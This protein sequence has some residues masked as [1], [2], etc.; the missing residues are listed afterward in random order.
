[1][2]GT[3]LLL[4]LLA[5]LVG[6]L[7]PFQAAANATLSRSLES[8]GYAALTLFAVALFST[9][10]LLALFRVPPPT[11][12][13]FSEAP[14]YGFL[15]GLVVATYV[16]SITF[17]VPR[18]GVA[19]AIF[20]IVTGQMVAAVVIDHFGWLGLSAKPVNGHQLAGLL[21]MCAG[22]MIARQH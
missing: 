18:I 1:M 5:L 6:G 15:G 22:L 3:L 14:V 16:L 19:Q 12:Q 4:S 7:I 20:L 13:A 10:L 11:L 8:I 9:A 2:K 21:L 17:L